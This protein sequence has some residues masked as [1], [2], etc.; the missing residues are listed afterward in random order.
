MQ[1]RSAALHFAALLSGVLYISVPKID[2]A[3]AGYM[4]YFNAFEG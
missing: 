1:R 2:E 4:P 3:A